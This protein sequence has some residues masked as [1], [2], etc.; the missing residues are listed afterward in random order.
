MK[1]SPRA[2]SKGR[3]WK[4]LRLLSVQNQDLPGDVS[5]TCLDLIRSK[6][7]VGGGECEHTD[8]GSQILQIRTSQTLREQPYR[9]PFVIRGC[10][11][12][13]HHIGH[14]VF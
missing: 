12:L 6:L 13:K 2:A 4:V 14:F 9:Y 5:S 7:C 1:G 11:D 8:A 3:C 10:Q